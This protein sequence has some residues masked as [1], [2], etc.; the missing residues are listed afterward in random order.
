M[1][2]HLTIG[3]QLSSLTTNSD[4]CHF[5]HCRQVNTPGIIS[6]T[7]LPRWLS[8]YSTGAQR[9][10]RTAQSFCVPKEEIVAQGYDFSLNLYKEQVRVEI[11]HRSPSE[12]L[13]D[14]AELETGI[15]DRN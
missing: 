7:C 11:E 6:L 4:L 10:V 1:V 3:V 8:R 9:S 5:R 12:I 14:L 15:Q 2:G 13:A